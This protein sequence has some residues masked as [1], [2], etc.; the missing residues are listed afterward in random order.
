MRE[1]HQG[2]GSNELIQLCES[3]LSMAHEDKLPEVR[4]SDD[5]NRKEVLI[6]SGF[7][8]QMRKKNIKLYE[9][10]HHQNKLVVDL[11]EIITAVSSY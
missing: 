9:M 4:P 7:D 2:S 6:I 11:P 1:Y 10:V 5:P 8:P 3:W